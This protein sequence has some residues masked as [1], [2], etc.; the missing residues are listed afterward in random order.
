M[1]YIENKEKSF[2]ILKKVSAHEN[3]PKNRMK[4]ATQLRS[5]CT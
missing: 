5:K 2:V 4:I 1:L 3:K